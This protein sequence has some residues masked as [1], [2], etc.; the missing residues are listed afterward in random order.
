MNKLFSII[1][2][3]YNVEKYIRRCL[4]SIYSQSVVESIFEVIVVNDGTPDNSMDIVNEFS[5]R[6]SNIVV[7]NKENGGV[8]SA[9]NVGITN[10]QGDFLIFVDPD[11][12]LCGGS[13]TKI[14][15]LLES[16][17]AD[18][19]ILRSYQSNNHHEENYKW[20]G[21]FE[22]DQVYVGGQL[23]EKAYIRGSACGCAINRAF[24]LENKLVF[25]E[26]IANFEDTIFMQLGMC[27]AQSIKFADI[28]LYDVFVREGS[29]S[30][31]LNKE[32]VLR[33]VKGLEFVEQYKQIHNLSDL[34]ISILEYLKYSIIS[35][36]TLYA[37]KCKEL[38]YREFVSYIDIKKYSPIRTS[39]V[40]TQNVKIRVLNFSYFLFY[41]LMSI[42]NNR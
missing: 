40:K 5:H 38:S 12:Y 17:F 25:P 30:T 22:I 29:A 27:Y 13:L 42:K 19:F 24:L 32:R 34:Q 2:P 28:D 6:H 37:I 3:V 4:E 36:V 39:L 8:S 31:T 14:Q 35:N 18:I 33:C 15:E 26:G 20:K 41:L 10:A 9:R 7:F 1:I 11:D 23:L 21:C 16:G